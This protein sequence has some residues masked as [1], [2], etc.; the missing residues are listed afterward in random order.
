MPQPQCIP[1]KA[2]LKRAEARESDD[3]TTVGG[4]DILRNADVIRCASIEPTLTPINSCCGQTTSRAG[5]KE[6]ARK[7]HEHNL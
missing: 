1:A 3:L 2:A 7:Q 5:G 6:L 4:I